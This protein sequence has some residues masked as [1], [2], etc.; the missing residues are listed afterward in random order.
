MFAG[1]YTIIVSTPNGYNA[2]AADVGMV[3][4]LSDGDE[5]SFTTISSIVVGA[6]Q[7]GIDY[8]FGVYPAPLPF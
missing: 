8:D 3:G 4:G 6:G 5:N 7:N 2:T 1:T